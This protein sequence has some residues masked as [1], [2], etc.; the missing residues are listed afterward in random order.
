MLVSIHFQ[1]IK[2]S[3]TFLSIFLNIPYF[4]GDVLYE[5]TR[6]EHITGIQLMISNIKK[7]IQKGRQSHGPGGSE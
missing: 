7:N 1:Q 2:K 5:S 6:D 3:N 4:Y